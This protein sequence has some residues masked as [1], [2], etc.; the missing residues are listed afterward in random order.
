MTYSTTKASATFVM[1]RYPEKSV[2]A[3]LHGSITTNNQSL[4]I[5]FFHR[6]VKRPGCAVSNSQAWKIGLVWKTKKSI[7]NHRNQS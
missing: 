5:N 4:D 3:T 7:L 2:S 6:G 1:L